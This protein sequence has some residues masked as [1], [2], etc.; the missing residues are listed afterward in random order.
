M[1][2]KNCVLCNSTEFDTVFILEQ[3]P[4]IQSFSDSDSSTDEYEDCIIIEC[5]K[6]KC[7]QLKTLID[8]NKLYA[9]SHNSTENTPTWK[10]HHETFAK[11]VLH[12]NIYNTILEIGGNSGV[13]F[14]YMH[15]NSIKHIILDICDNKNRH[16]NL[17]F[18]QG[19]CES[20]DFTG[21]NSLVLSHT[22]EHLYNPR[23]FIENIERS[24]VNSVFISIPNMDILYKNNNISIIHN[25]HTFF[26]G[27]KEIRYLF[28]QYGY[29]CKETYLFKSHSLFYYFVYDI[30]TP[31]EETIET[32]VNIKDIMTR[33][34]NIVNDITINM[35]CF[36]CPAGHYGQKLYYYLHRF[37]KYIKGFIDNDMLKQDK[38]V[39]GTPLYTF[40][41]DILLNY[42]ETSIYIILYAGPY[43]DELKS[44]LN[45]LHRSIIYITINSY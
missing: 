26:V 35:P 45:K 18:I 40:S 36:I 14:P 42:S 13:L 38:R 8:P 10:E 3:Y 25:E 9:N 16:S 29:S 32:R 12:N 44:Q 11:F 28:S 37:N 33:Y 2:R 4:I 21:Y 1:D 7:P 23:K 43:T 39:Y 15:L 5:L 20:F 34:K 27:N 41:P 24:K 22:F 19:N 31:I 30:T 6:C 17:E